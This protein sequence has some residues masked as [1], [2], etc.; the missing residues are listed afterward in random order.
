MKFQRF[1]EFVNEHI[2][3]SQLKFAKKLADT[4]FD[5]YGIDIEFTKHFLDRINDRRNHPMIKLT[6]VIEMFKKTAE[7][8]GKDL[9]IE[10]SKIEAVLKDI[11]TELNIPFALIPNENPE[12]DSKFISK[13]IMRK[14]DFKTSN[15]IFTV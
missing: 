15:K 9:E 7:Q 8:V 1:D 5:K 12:K 14:S 2:K 6:E 3:F 10:D 13:T 4:W 11:E